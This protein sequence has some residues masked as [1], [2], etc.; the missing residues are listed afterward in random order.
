[1]FITG[2]RKMGFKPEA[3]PY[4]AETLAVGDFDT[5]FYN[6]TY[7]L[8]IAEFKRKYATNDFAAFASVMGK[9]RGTITFSI[10]LAKAAAVDTAPKWGDVLES[11]GF[12]E[13]IVASTS[14]AYVPKASKNATPATIEVRESQVNESSGAE[15][16]L[17]IVLKGCMGNPQFIMDEVGMPVRM[18]FEFQGVIVS[19]TDKTGGSVITPTGFDVATPDAVLAST[20]TAFTEVQDLDSLNINM[21]NE[22]EITSD[23]ANAGGLRGAYITNR[24]PTMVIDPY[25]QLVAARDHFTRWTGNTTGAF[26]MTVGSNLTLSAPAIQITKAFDGADRNGVVVNTLNF[27]LTRKADGDSETFKILHN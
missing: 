15:E 20:L 6:V 19:I 21:N 5:R 13:T 23:P 11:C 4:T 12:L 8:D 16:Q 14:V 22:I 17:A 9:R 25:L 27:L 3:T 26:S 1:M 2:K 18:D 7:D 24:E 10:D